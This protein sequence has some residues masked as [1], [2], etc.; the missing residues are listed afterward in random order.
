MLL[1]TAQSLFINH[2]ET[3]RLETLIHRVLLSLGSIVSLTMDIGET[4]CQLK[5]P[6]GLKHAVFYQIFPDRF[7][8][9]HH[10]RH[11]PEMAVPL[12]P[13]TTSPSLDG[14]K[15]GDLWGAMEQLDYL[16]D[17]GITAIYLT[18]IFQSA[19]NHRYHTHDYYQVDPLLGGN[20]AFH[21]FLEAA[22]PT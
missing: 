19:S 9:T 6:I 7:A 2:C 1:A 12:E 21:D 3:I 15:G 22:Q 4:S 13:W 20:Q 16:Q 5:H 17:L 18:P 14:Y 10:P 8:R 11:Q